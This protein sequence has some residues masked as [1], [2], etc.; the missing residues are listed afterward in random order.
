[1]THVNIYVCVCVCAAVDGNK[2]DQTFTGT[3]DCHS[4][5]SLPSKLLSAMPNAWTAQSG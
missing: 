4:H 5:A 1:M 2:T 3:P